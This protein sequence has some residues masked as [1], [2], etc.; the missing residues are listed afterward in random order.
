MLEK[1]IIVMHLLAALSVIGLIWLHP[2]AVVRRRRY[3]VLVVAA[4]C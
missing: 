3:S 1:L 2:L 4:M